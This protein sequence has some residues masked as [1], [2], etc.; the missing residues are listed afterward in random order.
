MSSN[1]AAASPSPSPAPSTP[2]TASS[3]C[4][5]PSKPKSR[6]VNLFSNDGSF[7][8]RFQRNKKEENEKKAAENLTQKKRTFEDR[9][10]NRGKRP[11]PSDSDGAAGSSGSAA[12]A[13]AESGGSAKK[14]KTDKVL[15]QYEKEVQSYE[16]R[17]LKDQGIGVRPLVK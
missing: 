7:L 5:A 2:A 17:S 13:A 11:A 12:A 15:T 9:F 16:S 1:S 6:P 10:K 14:L 3:V 8:E 4:L